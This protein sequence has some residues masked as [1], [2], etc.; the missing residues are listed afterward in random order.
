MNTVLVLCTGNIC[1]SPVAEALF[2]SALPGRNVLSAGLDAV[3][4]CPPDPLATQFMLERNIDI[5]SHRGQQVAT[6]MLRAADLILVM[7]TRQQSIVESHY[8]TCKGK[9]FRMREFDRQDIADPYG[10]GD[11]AMVIA[12]ESIADAVQQWCHRLNL[13]TNKFASGSA[14]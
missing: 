10:K 9:V 11:V 12:V 1:R 13:V 4:G 5:S 7:E 8:P 3:V 14:A 6:W 2:R